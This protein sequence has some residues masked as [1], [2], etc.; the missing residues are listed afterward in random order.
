LDEHPN[1]KCRDANRHGDPGHRLPLP[2]YGATSTADHR[3]GNHDREYGTAHKNRRHKN[4]CHR[5]QGDV[6]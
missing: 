2:R 5:Q 4:A 1:S 6:A 3:G